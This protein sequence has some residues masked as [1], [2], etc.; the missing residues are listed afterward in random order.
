MNKKGKDRKCLHCQDFFPPNNYN[1]HVQEFCCRTD[2]CKKASSCASSRKYRKKKQDDRLWKKIE[3]DRVKRYQNK[4]PDYWKSEKK[5]K[6]FSSNLLLRDFAQAQ[7]IDSLP[8]LRDF[9]LY[10]SACLTGFI[11][12]TTDLS[13]DSLLRD[14]AFSSLNKFYDKGIALSGERK[15]QSFKEENY[16]DSERN[17]KTRSP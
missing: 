17:R 3:C 8:L 14:F 5:V 1:A 11:A 6:I 15:S 7:K 13:D 10:Y 4:H 2:K 16:H 12:H 9:V